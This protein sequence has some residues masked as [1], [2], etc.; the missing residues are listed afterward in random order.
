MNAS[1]IKIDSEGEEQWHF[2]YV[3]GESK[4]S[5]LAS[6]VELVGGGY[7]AVG[8]S[9]SRAF[10][11]RTDAS[12]TAL[13]NST[14]GADWQYAVYSVVAADDGGFIV[15]G[16]SDDNVWLA[17]FTEITLLETDQLITS[18]VIV[19]GVIVAGLGFLIYLMK[20]R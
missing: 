11:V 19:V 14:Y 18:V 8:Y 7:I 17:K 10:L 15:A 9:D 16:S 20:R 3:S 2:N 5:R 6:V 4:Y 12:G 13:W 1:L